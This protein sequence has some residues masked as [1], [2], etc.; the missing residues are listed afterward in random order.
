MIRGMLSSDIVLNLDE[1][2]KKFISILKPIVH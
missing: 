2:I 1:K